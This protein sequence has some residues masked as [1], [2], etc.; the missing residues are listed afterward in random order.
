MMNELLGKKFKWT[1]GIL[2]MVEILSFV[3]YFFNVGNIIFIG[4][5][6][7]VLGVTLYKLEYGLMIALV[8]L[9]IGSMGYLFYFDTDGGKISIRMGIWLIIIS[10]WA[11]K[12]I[13]GIIDNRREGKTLKTQ[14]QHLLHFVKNNYLAYF[15]VLF[16]F[17]A[18][19]F[20]MGILNNNG[21]SSLFLDANG[22]AFFL[23]IFPVYRSISGHQ[24]TIT[25]YKYGIPSYLFQ[26]LGIFFAAAT[27]VVIKSLLLLF[28]FSHKLYQV[29]DVIYGWIRATQVGE[30]TQMSEGVYRIFFQSHLF[31]IL[32]FFL[33]LFLLSKYFFRNY[34]SIKQLLRTEKYNTIFSFLLLGAIFA[35][36]IIS[37]SRSFWM[38]TFTGILLW[39]FFLWKQF[40]WK[41]MLTALGGLIIIAGISLGMI[42]AITSFP[43]PSPTGQFSAT[44]A[45]SSRAQQTVS[46]GAAVA[47]RWS[48]LPP[49]WKKIKEAPVLGSGFGATITYRSS[50]PRIL[51]STV[52]GKYTTFALEWGWLDI[53]LKLGALGL[54]CYIMLLG[55]L[56]FDGYKLSRTTPRFTDPLITGIAIVVVIN[57]FTPFLNHPLGIG[58]LILAAAW[59]DKIR[60]GA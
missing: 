17:I 52:N 25:E 53:W 30:I 39:I 15:L 55:K 24:E 19:G 31:L 57:F 43:Y 44:Q 23:L 37:F 6:L 54:I 51:E 12:E 18:W 13:K 50:D 16:L 48:M 36:I 59:L 45:V 21:F 58:Y 47:S 3:A 60:D 28:L 32:G 33:L 46:G 35:V 41:R 7:S 8:E 26:V 5:L 22:Y 34:F 11:A 10:V 42:V 27:W 29:M 56:F 4:I 14:F 2:L 1:L 40:Y 38:G 9:I 49:L 20:T